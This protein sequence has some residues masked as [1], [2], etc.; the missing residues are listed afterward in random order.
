MLYRYNILAA[1]FPDNMIVSLQRIHGDLQVGNRMEKQNAL[2][3]IDWERTRQGNN[4][5][6]IQK[7]L[8]KLLG[9]TPLE[10][11]KFINLLLQQGVIDDY[12]AFHC[13]EV[14]FYLLSCALDLLKQ[15]ISLEDFE[16]KIIFKYNTYLQ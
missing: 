5:Q 3:F 2:F 14:F 7:F 4:A 9:Y 11:D 12:E 15:R 13:L 10:T 1:T 6:D 8:Y 16:K